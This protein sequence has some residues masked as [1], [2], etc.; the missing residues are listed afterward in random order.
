[1][2]DKP[3]VPKTN[4]CRLLERGNVPYTLVESH[5]V[6]DEDWSSVKTSQSLG[7]EAGR[8]FKTLVLRGDKNR[9]L[10]CCVPSDSELDMKKVA[11]ASGDK[12]VEMIHVK[13][14]RDI[15]GYVRGGCSP[16][17]MKKPFPTFF[18]ET[19]ILY[20]TI[21]INAGAIN[22]AV[23]VEPNRLLEFLSAKAADLTADPNHK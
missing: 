13:E 8:I 12:R 19:L 15:T 1:M 6:H 23:E 5:D 18:D 9:F 2:K 20:D 16:I 4:V 21:F 17:G 14:L 11:R 22:M 7:V 3:S 10:V